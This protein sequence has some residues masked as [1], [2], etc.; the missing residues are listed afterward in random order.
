M[1]QSA[2]TFKAKGLNF[3]GVVATPDG[4]GPWPG[5]VMCHPHPL[6][7]GSMDNNVVLAVTLGLVDEGY[8]TMRFNFRGVGGSEGE[9]TKGEE[10]YH[11]VLA[12]LELL[13]AWEGVDKNRLGLGGYSF[14]SSVVLGSPQLHKKAKVFFLVS[15]P[16]RA[17]ESTELK[18]SDRPALIVAGDRD[19]LVE[20]DQLEPEL[21]SF[22]H[23]PQRQIFPGVDHYWFGQESRLVPEIAQFLNEQLK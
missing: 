20:S 9:H 8:A 16:L 18:K 15:P 13:A 22:Q 19:K 14:G 6:F 4:E 11:E 10:E 7:G 1:R 5:V 23:R 17:V 2:V 3:D 12:A 21:D